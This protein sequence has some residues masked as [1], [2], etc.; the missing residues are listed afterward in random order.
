MIPYTFLLLPFGVS[1][2]T[3]GVARSSFTFNTDDA[4]ILIDTFKARGKEI[5]VDYE[6][7]TLSGTEAPAAGWIDRLFLTPEGL[8]AH[9]R[10]WTSKAENFLKMKEYRYFSPVLMLQNGHPISL[11]SVGLTNHP[12]IHGL[13]PLV[14]SDIYSF[15]TT[16]GILMTPL[17][18]LMEPLGLPPSDDPASAL[19]EHVS[20]LT[21]RNNDLEKFLVEQECPDLDAVTLKIKGMIPPADWAECQEKLR[22]YESEKAVEQAFSDGKLTESQRD[23][24]R[25]YATQNLSAFNDFIRH[26]PLVAP[27]PAPAIRLAPST[28]KIALSDTERH[29]LKISGCSESQI[30]RYQQGE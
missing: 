26:A 17:E 21:K 18:S 29:I 10:E 27:G 22:R 25:V 9:V 2:T 19:I 1:R 4:R 5:V 14:S 23:W 6:H 12:A 11:H 8:Q 15:N 20:R 28:H 16:Q 24:A 13:S 30:N 7:Q 3:H